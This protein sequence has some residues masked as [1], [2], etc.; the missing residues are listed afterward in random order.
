MNSLVH[1]LF[2]QICFNFIHD[3]GR[4][5]IY[6]SFSCFA[7]RD[8]TVVISIYVNE[9]KQCFANKYSKWTNTFFQHSNAE[10]RDG[11]FSSE[12]KFDMTLDSKVPHA[13]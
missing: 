4:Q 11:F 13:I 12:D 7:S 3:N 10:P 2:K 1:S 6:I 5:G 9:Y 8:K